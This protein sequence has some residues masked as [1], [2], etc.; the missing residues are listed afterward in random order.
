M[1]AWNLVSEQADLRSWLTLPRSAQVARFPLPEGE[2]T[3]TLDGST[4]VRLTIRRQRPTL[5]RV[6]R[7]EQHL[8][9]AAWPL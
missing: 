9:T 2:Q 7:V 5:L 1:G 3:L 4:P 8:Y 6:V